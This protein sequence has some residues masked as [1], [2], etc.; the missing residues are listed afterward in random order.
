MYFA[1]MSTNEYICVSSKEWDKMINKMSIENLA[2][3]QYP[4]DLSAVNRY[5]HLRPKK[6]HSVVFSTIGYNFHVLIYLEMD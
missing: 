3:C 5:S 2:I 6:L 1:A 4:E